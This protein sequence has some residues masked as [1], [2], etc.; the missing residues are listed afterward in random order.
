M[1][2]AEFPPQGSR[3]FELL[4]MESSCQNNEFDVGAIFCPYS[5]V[6]RPHMIAIIAFNLRALKASAFWFE[7]CA[8][9]RRV[10]LVLKA[11]A[12]KDR[13]IVFDVHIEFADVRR[14][15]VHDYCHQTT[16][17]AGARL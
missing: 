6:K 16:V 8:E 4:S 14:E 5:R 2:A 13:V 12:R 15:E 17:S 1:I 9:G 10:E 3:E 7:T 11:V